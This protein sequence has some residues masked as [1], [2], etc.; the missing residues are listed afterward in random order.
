MDGSPTVQERLSKSDAKGRFVRRESTFRD[1]VTAD[2]SSGFKVEPGR[3][4]LYV[5]YACPWAH[6]TLLTRSFMGLE[7]AIS[8][9]VV[10]HRMRDDGVWVFTGENGS[11]RDSIN[12]RETV[13][14]I[15][16]RSDPDFH[17]PGTVPV[18][19]DKEQD[20]IV[21][22]ESRDIVR[23]FTTAFG[24]VGEPRFDLLPD[25]E[26][27]AIDAMITANY[28]PVNNGVYKAG[29]ARS[30]EAYDEAVTTLFDRLDELES[31]LQENRF[32]MGEQMTE[33]D[34][35]LWPTLAR[36]DLVY[37]THFKCNLRCI[38]D[39]PALHRYLMDFY[40]LP[41]VA[42]T[43]DFGH[44]KRHYYESHASINPYRIVPIGP[45]PEFTTQ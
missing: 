17:G 28:E 14:D 3:Y 32:L 34:I 22:D 39:Y 23:M 8:V 9:D 36:F 37:V 30:Q 35:C 1:K 21:N 25:G 19:Y 45:E 26:V 4:H 11:D 13:Q 18:L 31:H 6:R 5:Q 24:D 2:G 41:G 10:D 29:F 27:D 43:C 15:Y 16:L 42:G 12:G 40:D 33:A 20:T 44:M 38:R 7:D